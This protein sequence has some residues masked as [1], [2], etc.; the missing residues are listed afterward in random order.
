MKSIKTKKTTDGKSF[1]KSAKNIVFS[2]TFVMFTLLS[3]VMIFNTFAATDTIDA[4]D[5]WGTKILDLF[6]SSWVKVICLVALIVEAIGMVVAGQQG[7]GGA[8]IKKFAPWIIGT[9]ILLS[10]SSICS[11]FLGDL[12][13]E[14]SA[15]IQDSM[16]R[17]A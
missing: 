7:G 1:F 4:L 6:S 15:L 16:I 10:A 9:I 17:L 3:C 11:Y 13:F 14:L 2:K 12:K 8:I 5:S